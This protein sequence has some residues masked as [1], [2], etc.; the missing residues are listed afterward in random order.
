[1]AIYHKG[2]KHHEDRVAKRALADG[3][4]EFLRRLQ[5]EMNTQDT[6]ATADPR[7]WVIKGSE[8]CRD[9]NDPETFALRVSDGVAAENTED[10]CK[11]LNADI[12]P[13]CDSDD[14]TDFQIEAE[15]GFSHEFVLRY[16][17][18]DGDDC[19]EYL[20]IDELN[21]FLDENGTDCE[22]FG[23]SKR[24]VVYPNTMFLT[25]KEAMEHLEANDYHYSK[26]AHTYCMTAWRSPDVER[27]W[28]ILQE[29]EW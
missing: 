9:D 2:L 8:M 13:D 4:R 5:H 12:M 7:F 29:V 1:M 22:V 20:D 15:H 10:T 3:D 19:F 28:K 26:D 6:A 16:K 25:E 18:E 14:R 27:L 11:T 17:D 24:S 23:Q 21:E